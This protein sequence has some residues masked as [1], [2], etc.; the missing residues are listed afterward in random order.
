MT[1]LFSLPLALTAFTRD[2][3]AISALNMDKCGF[4]SVALKVSG[5]KQDQTRAWAL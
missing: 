5:Q 3:E 4:T 2:S 1:F